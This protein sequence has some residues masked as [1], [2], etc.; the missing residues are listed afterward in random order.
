MMMIIVEIVAVNYLL[1]VTILFL[2][3]KCLNTFGYNIKIL[4]WISEAPNVLYSF[5]ATELWFV[6]IFY[7]LITYLKIKK[8]LF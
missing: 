1:G 3:E 6:I 4:K 8:K 5:L 2:T 7:Y